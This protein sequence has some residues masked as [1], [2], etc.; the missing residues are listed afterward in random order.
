[1]EDCI[2]EDGEGRGKV[3][4]AEEEGSADRGELV[5]VVN[6]DDD[7]ATVIRLSCDCPFVIDVVKRH[8]WE[9]MAVDIDIILDIDILLFKCLLY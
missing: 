4:S 5:A 1:V 8:V 9:D 6:N 3:E 7:T 2:D